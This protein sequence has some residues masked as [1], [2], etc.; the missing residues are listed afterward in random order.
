MRPVLCHTKASE[1]SYSPLIERKTKLGQAIV[2]GV[3]GKLHPYDVP[4]NIF[5]F[6]PC[7]WT[8][9]P[10]SVLTLN[11]IEGTTTS[12]EN[13]SPSSAFTGEQTE[14]CASVSVKCRFLERVPRFIPHSRIA[15]GLIRGCHKV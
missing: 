9:V 13:S 7:Q 8:T 3:I 1:R 12:I 11:L 10:S 14:K 2:D 6:P 4:P 15:P 5:F